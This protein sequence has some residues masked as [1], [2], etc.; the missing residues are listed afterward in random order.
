MTVQPSVH[1]ST[2]PTPS[3]PGR[4]NVD[5]KTVASHQNKRQPNEEAV[6]SARVREGLRRDSLRKQREAMKR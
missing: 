1:G 3:L 5:S 2:I 4:C 6:R